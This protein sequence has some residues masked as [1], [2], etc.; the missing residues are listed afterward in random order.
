MSSAAATMKYGRVR[1]YY[2]GE[3]VESKTGEWLDVTSPIDGALLSQVPM[4]TRDELDVAVESAKK[5]FEGWSK[6]TIK[7]RVQIFFRYRSLL[8]MNFD[9]GDAA[10]EDVLNR[11]LWFSVHGEKPYPEEYVGRPD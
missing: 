2:G 10:D 11:I 6:T 9:D 5:A 8:E 3:F 1:N 4:S 7:E